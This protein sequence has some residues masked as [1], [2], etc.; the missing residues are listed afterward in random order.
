VLSSTQNGKE[1]AAAA[2]MADPSPKADGAAPSS[3][4]SRR[5]RP[6]THGT[7]AMI[8]T[9]AEAA[10]PR[11]V[12]AFRGS[13]TTTTTTPAAAAAAPPPRVGRHLVQQQR[14][15]TVRV[16][17]ILPSTLFAPDLYNHLFV[18]VKNQMLACSAQ[19]IALDPYSTDP[20]EDVDV[21]TTA[22]S[23][24]TNRT[25]WLQ[26]V[27]DQ[28]MLTSTGTSATENNGGPPV[29]SVALLRATA[30]HVVVIL[31]DTYPSSISFVATAEVAHSISIFHPIW[32]LSLSTYM[33]EFGTCV[34]IFIVVLQATTMPLVYLVLVCGLL[35]RGFVVGYDST[36]VFGLCTFRYS[37]YSSRGT[38]LGSPLFL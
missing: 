16:L 32:A 33:H 26:A 19:S 36:E 9:A 5:L 8:A 21:G 29:D 24:V 7:T 37:L 31:P 4:S 22:V 14:R 38:P 3:S 15:R 6:T 13:S 34:G 10:A 25:Q 12:A 28:M 27:A 11:T 17:R 35:A 30:D 2:A 20:I 18:T 23:D 1:A